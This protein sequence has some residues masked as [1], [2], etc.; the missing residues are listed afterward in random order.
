MCTNLKRGFYGTQY[1]PIPLVEND[2]YVI[3]KRPICKDL[4]VESIG[5]IQDNNCCNI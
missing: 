5:N 4:T 3:K 1:H 2:S